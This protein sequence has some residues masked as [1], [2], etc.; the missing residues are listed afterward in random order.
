MHDSVN[1][2]RYF[3][4][5]MIVGKDGAGKSSLLRRLLKEDTKNVKST[6]GIDIVVRRC[7]INTETGKWII[8][9]NGN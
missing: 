9:K 3:V 6:D 4:K 7:K 1:E 8:D 2:K 5:L